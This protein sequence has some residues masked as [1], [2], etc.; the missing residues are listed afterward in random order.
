VL[1]AA[2]TQQVAD[3]LI[4]PS[5][6][7]TRRKAKAKAR[8]EAGQP[9]TNSAHQHQQRI[10][11]KRVKTEPTDSDNDAQH[12]RYI[13]HEGFKKEERDEEDDDEEEEE[14][15]DMDE[16]TEGESDQG[17]DDSSSNEEKVERK[18]KRR[19]TEY[20]ARGD[21]AKGGGRG[22]VPDGL[23]LRVVKLEKASESDAE[24]P[25]MDRRFY[26]VGD[27]GE[28]KRA[29]HDQGTETKGGLDKEA[30]VKPVHDGHQPAATT[31]T[32]GPHDQP[33]LNTFMWRATQEEAFDRALPVDAFLELMGLQ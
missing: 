13:K 18:T 30:S 11:G 31:T 19:R 10:L 27:K 25:R 22:A 26:A 5:K 29:P 17:V 33:H 3:G 21:G 7:K 28:D 24:E 2:R 16:E 8:G 14:E 4:Y 23:V 32:T 1:A 9:A 15:E 12:E 20:S 6:R